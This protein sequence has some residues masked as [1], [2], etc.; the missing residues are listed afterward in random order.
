[1]TP[2]QDRPLIVDASGQPMRRPADAHCP[3]CGAAPDRRM[4]SSGFGE[5]H[6]VCV[7]CGHDFLGER[8]A[9]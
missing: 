9:A 4:R 5:W 7:N 1:V 6:D 2:D 8:T 3:R